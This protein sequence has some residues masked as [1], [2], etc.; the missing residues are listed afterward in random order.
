MDRTTH[1]PLPGM[2]TPAAAAMAGFAPAAVAGT[3]GPARPLGEP[4]S[5]LLGD[6]R[7]DVTTR[8]L[9]RGNDS[10]SIEPL[11]MAVLVAL[12]R[13]PGQVIS[14]ESLLQ[15]C[16]PDTPAQGDNPVHKVVAGLRRALHDSAT[17]PVYLETI[18]K[19]GYRLL[20]PVRVLS[21]QG[22]RSHAEGWRGQSPFCG[23][24]AFDQAHAS[25]FFGRDAA[26]A[27]L[28][29]RLGQQWRR[30]H[31]LVVLLGPSGS[32]KTSLVQAGLLPAL[33]QLPEAAGAG[34]ADG[35]APLR[36]C[37][38]ATVDLGAVGRRAGAARL[39]AWA[40]LAGALLDWDCHG[41]PLLSG[42]SIDSLST[43][44]CERP[45]DVLRQLAIGLDATRGLRGGATTPPLLVLDRLEALLQEDPAH[46]DAWFDTLERLVRSGLVL[47]LAVCRNDFYAALARRPLLMEGKGSGAHLDLAPPQASEIAQMIRLPARA[48]GL[49]YGSDDSG[50]NRL[51]DR[52][53][54]DAMQSPDAL[55][56]LQ[57]T[58]QQLYLQRDAGGVLAWSA[59][60]AVG[61]LEGAIG[62]R[63]EALLGELPAAQQA[64]LSPLLSRLVTLAGDEAAPTSRW[65]PDAELT[66]AHER[67]LVEAFVEARLLVA[68]LAT[69]GKGYR[70]AHEALLRRWPRVTAWVASHR[71][72]LVARDSLAP[73]LAR[74][75]EAGQAQALLLP[76][77]AALWTAARAL[78]EAPDL[79]GPQEREFIQRSQRRLRR[80]RWNLGAATA[81]ALLLAA[82]AITAAIG[83]AHQADL[84]AE[85]DRESRQ[86]AS[87][88]LGEL[89]DGLR[90]IGKLDLLSRIGEQGLKLLSPADGR[91]T[92]GLASDTLQRARALVVIGEVNSSRGQGRTD[93]AVDALTAARRL[94]EALEPIDRTPD[95][96]PAEFFRTL[97]AASFWLGQI[98]FDASEM[99]A[100]ADA[101]SRY[102]E[103]SERWRQAAP[104][105]A[106]AKAELG[107]ALQ[108]LGSIEFR[109]SHW[110]A[111][112][113]SFRES[114]ALKLEALSKAPHNME[115]REAVA[116][117]RTWLGLVAHVQG[118]PHEA[119][120][121]L[122]A[123][124]EVRV[125][126]AAARS[127]E[128]LRLRD[129]GTLDLRR[130]DA[131]HA[132]GRHAEAA[133]AVASGVAR[134]RDAQRHDPSNRYWRADRLHA[135]AHLLL[136]RL[137]AGL[138][139][140]AELAVLRA[141]LL[142]EAPSTGSDPAREYLRRAALLRVA[143]VDAELAA[144]RRD[145]LRVSQLLATTG[146]ELTAVLRLR[147]DYWQAREL[148]ARR[149]LLALR[150]AAAPAGPG[151]A[152]CTRLR[153]DMQPAVDAGQAGLVLEAW[154]AARA[155]AGTA[156]D[157]SLKQRL[158]AGGYVA[159][160]PALAA[161]FSS[162]PTR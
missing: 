95:I 70:V 86:L 88:M 29:E 56:L 147:P 79:F 5:F 28:R 33:A 6:W 13:Q 153:D 11:P 15:A 89:A 63:A 133:V 74:W 99:D 39:D 105:D 109:R 102:R 19:Q 161:V 50:L 103:A 127:D 116:N 111:A 142:A 35:D 138:P 46:T 52:L 114:L 94:L 37:T 78:A 20:A 98:A 131:L 107:Y 84:A 141:Q 128:Q 136:A 4:T 139:V 49:S 121:H 146:D 59:Y 7:V 135:E 150:A 55:P 30:G 53:C 156:P 48:A 47:V 92:A 71:A 129:L 66:D 123:A 157:D 40:G 80:Q 44:L 18:R 24:E 81:G 140:E 23:L 77:G 87:F 27:A 130:G 148:Q 117:S 14:A 10:V 124:R 160:H 134:L 68:D 12:C 38:T 2:A 108:S 158:A 82:V 1:G 22:P 64:A 154:M 83:Y 152:G 9:S 75:V 43:A 115:A 106:A 162:P 45:H 91:D 151:R 119:L 97:G 100:A 125:A 8:R 17:Q 76:R 73:W 3:G 149:A 72:A 90:P 41:V 110:Q 21:E 32:G 104:D 101:M 42:F 57:Y 85:R 16:W 113:R 122:D 144:R 96:R 65:M 67:A 112:D 137:D 54:A 69:S 145:W 36:V 61:G 118:R 26:V 34:V 132:A 58:L 93:I 60:E 51:D 120:T 126:L 62:R 159:M 25:V 155:C 31:P 143:V